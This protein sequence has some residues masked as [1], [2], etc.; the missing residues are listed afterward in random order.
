M[1]ETSGSWLVS[2]EEKLLINCI[3]WLGFYLGLLWARQRSVPLDSSGLSTELCLDDNLHFFSY[4]VLYSTSLE[5]SLLAAPF[6]S[7]C[8]WWDSLQNPISRCPLANCVNLVC[9]IYL[10]I[11]VPEF[12]PV[13]WLHFLLPQAWNA[14]Y[15]GRSVAHAAEAVQGCNMLRLSR[16]E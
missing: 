8:L 10:K 6:H 9:V 11:H 13:F 12:S 2:G 3:V 5:Q 4:F 1:L 15:R 14:L 7:S 16:P